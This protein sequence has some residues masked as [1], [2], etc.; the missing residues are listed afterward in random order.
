VDE[1]DAI[2]VVLVDD[3]H[4]FR[5]GLRSLLREHGFEIAGEA[6]SGEAAIGL[7]LELEPDVVVMD[8]HMPGIS[9]VEATRRL[10]ERGS[11]ARILVL[12]VSTADAEVVEAM[13]AGACRYLLKD[14]APDQITAGVEA[15]AAAKHHISN[16]LAKLG[17]K[18]RVQ[19]ATYAV[20]AGMV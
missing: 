1:K 9:G 2:R 20:R 11:S 7:T 14:T 6:T 18:S 12:T 19:T 8:L 10:S 15:A 13:V 3:H 4:F 16:I 5:Q 17:V